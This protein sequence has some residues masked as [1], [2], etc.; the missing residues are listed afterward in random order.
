MKCA[1]IPTVMFNVWYFLKKKQP[2]PIA[3]RKNQYKAHSVINFHPQLCYLDAAV[4]SVLGTEEQQEHQA[5]D[6]QKSSSSIENGNSIQF[7][8]KRTSN[9]FFAFSPPCPPELFSSFLVIYRTRQK[10]SKRQEKNICNWQL[11]IVNW[12]LFLSFKNC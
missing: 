10:A 2:V 3:M 12:L 7:G 4:Y 1:A 5:V 9:I 11:F 8:E 6:T